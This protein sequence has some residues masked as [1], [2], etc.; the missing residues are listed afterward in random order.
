MG[1]DRQY[2]YAM[3]TSQSSSQKLNFPQ[4]LEL[5]AARPGVND[6]VKNWCKAE[7]SEA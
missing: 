2:M 5:E 3:Q 1:E 7:F 4:S 6:V